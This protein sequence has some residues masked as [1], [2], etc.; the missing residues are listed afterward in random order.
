ME[1]GK[2]DKSDFSAEKNLG[3]L[4]EELDN[5]IDNLNVSIEEF[6]QYEN[7]SMFYLGGTLNKKPWQKLDNL[8]ITD[9]IAT[10]SSYMLNPNMYD[11]DAGYI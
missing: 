5:P 11:Y 4:F 8:I 6:K 2:L 10:T 3:N 7:W 9:F 1:S